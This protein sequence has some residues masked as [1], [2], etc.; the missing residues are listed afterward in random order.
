M[1]GITFYFEIVLFSFFG[2]KKVFSVVRVVRDGSY[3]TWKKK[4]A[5][6]CQSPGFFF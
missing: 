6:L 2:V 4:L 3:L 5:T 1:G